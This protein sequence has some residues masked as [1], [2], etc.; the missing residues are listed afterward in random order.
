MSRILAKI[1]MYLSRVDE[2]I[3]AEI[4]RDVHLRQPEVSI[5]MQE[6]QRRGWIKKHDFKNNGKGRPTHIYSMTTSIDQIVGIFGEKKLK[7]INSVKK[8]LTL[9]KNLIEKR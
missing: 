7:E 2:C 6:L 5:A 1:L 8:D 3:S 9:L 4:E